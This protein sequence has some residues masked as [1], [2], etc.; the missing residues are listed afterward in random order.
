[1]LA[2]LDPFDATSLSTLRSVLAGLDPDGPPTL[3]ALQPSRRA[4]AVCLVPGSFNPPTVAHVALADR[5][6]N[7]GYDGVHFVYSVRTVGKRPNGLVPEDRLLLTRAAAPSGVG[8]CVSSAGLLADMA[9]AA[10]QA[11]DPTDLAILVGGDKLEQLFEHRWYADR[12][13]ALEQ[14]FSLARVLVAPRRD[15][16]ERIEEILRAHPRWGPRVDVL[17]LHPSIAEVSST[18]VRQVLRAGGDPSGLV[19]EPVASFLAEVAAFAPAVRFDGVARDRYAMRAQLFD[20][21]L[22]G[23]C[24]RE[25]PNLRLLWRLAQDPGPQGRELRALLRAGTPRPSASVGS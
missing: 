8:V 9:V 14:L 25:V 1:M 5:A 7:E 6:R 12:D 20:L 16:T 2:G 15:E 10:T 23:R 22:D 11:F 13:A 24:T 17:H 19:P 3:V 21:V 4:K 18:R